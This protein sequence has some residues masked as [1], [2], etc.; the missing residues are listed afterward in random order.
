MRTAVE[1]FT[2]M[3]GLALGLERVGFRHLALVEWDRKA[4]DTVRLNHPDWPLHEGDAR[5][6]SFAALPQDI[7][8]LA[9]GPPCQ[10]FSVGGKHRGRGDHRDMFP[11]VVR[12]QRALRPKAIFIENVHGLT[13]SAFR[14][15]FEYI[16]LQ[17]RFPFLVAADSEEN[18]ESHKGRLLA[19]SVTKGN[20]ASADEYDVDFAIV[21][22]ADYGVP[23]VR[24]RVVIV[25]VRRDL[26]VAW[27]WNAVPLTHSRES[28]DHAQ[29]VDGSYWAEHGLPEPLAR[30]G[31]HKNLPARKPP[32]ERWRTV[33]D[34]LRGLPE[35]VFGS[36]DLGY[37]NHIGI[38]G[39]RVYPGH[40][41]NVLDKPAKT[42]KAGDHGCPGGEHV[43]V[44][45][46]GSIRYFT[47]RECARLQGFPDQL[48]FEC[49]RTEAMRQLGN[50]VPVPLAEALGSGL[51]RI[52]RGDATGSQRPTRT[53]QMPLEWA[54]PAS[55]QSGG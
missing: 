42:V 22:T 7:D 24:R 28:L 47:V 1:L 49:S 31:G 35:P 4:C 16:L 32:L 36:D 12:A 53:S 23:Q 40:T 48:R 54:S 6:F 43:L 10:P 26:S 9:G 18:W 8:L 55:H 3:G 29:V 14:P 34:A 46:D 2:G 50:A 38:P 13:R 27:S 21:N 19:H 37:R 41:G 51:V 17:L 45:D 39:A 52:L 20:R 44:R 5:G 15:Y 30:A 33:R 25:G 11:E